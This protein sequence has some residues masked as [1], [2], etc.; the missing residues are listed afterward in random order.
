MKRRAA[1]TLLELLLAMAIVAII[2][3]SLFASLAIAFKA[4]SS[5]MAA[6]EPART[7]TLAI[8]FIREDLLSAM[9]PHGQLASAFTGVDTTDDRGLPG[10]DLTFYTVAPAG[11]LHPQGGNGEIRQVEYT[12]LTPPNS[13]DHVLVRKVS[14]NLLATV[15]EDPDQEVICRNVA[16]FNLRY[17]DG[18]AWQDSWDSTTYSNTLPVAIELTLQIQKPGTTTPDQVLTYTQTFA[19]PCSVPPTVQE[20]ATSAAAGSATGASSSGSGSGSGTGKTGATGS[21]TGGTGGMTR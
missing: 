16:G 7:A 21:G 14:N 10:D 6:V 13:S 17:Y 20:A 1:F 12:V 9:P 2:A 11:P 5:A 19:M 18:S 15:T 4:R 3:V 8:D